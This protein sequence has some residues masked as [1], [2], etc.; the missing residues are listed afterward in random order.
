VAATAELDRKQNGES[1][2][3]ED[4]EY[5]FHDFFLSGTASLSQSAPVTQKLMG[6]APA[7]SLGIVGDKAGIVG[8]ANCAALSQ[9]G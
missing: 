9:A 7:I 5:S 1:G 4:L 2:R 3:H 6:F 8:R